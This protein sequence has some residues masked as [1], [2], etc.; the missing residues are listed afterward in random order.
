LLANDLLRRGNVDVI[1]V[2]EARPAFAYE[3]AQS[4]FAFEQ[5]QRT[6]IAPVQ[7]EQ[8]KRADQMR[9]T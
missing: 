6:Q 8:I 2:S 1:D 7:K 5:R 4:R 9:S 3:F